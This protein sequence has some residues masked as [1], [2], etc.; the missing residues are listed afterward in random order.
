[1]AD[2]PDWKKQLQEKN[3]SRKLSTD[4]EQPAVNINSLKQMEAL[5]ME[6]INMVA[7]KMEAKNVNIRIRVMPSGFEFV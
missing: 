1:M 2:T 7:I 5:K 6:A 4:V 3:K